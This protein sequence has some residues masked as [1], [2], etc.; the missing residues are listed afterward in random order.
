[1]PLKTEV[2]DRVPTY[3]GRVK[4]TPVS[5]LTNIYDMERADA[6]VTEGTPLNAAL[7]NQKAYTLIGAATV[8]VSKTGSD[9]VGDGSEAAPFASVQKAIDSLPKC[10]GGFH[11]QIDIGAGTYEE[12]VTIDG[13][14]G[15]RL[16]VGVTG[17]TVTLR[18]ITVMSSS[19]VRINISNLTYS[20]NYAGTLLYADHGSNVSIINALTLRGESAAVSGIAAARGSIITASVT[21]AVLG[22]GAAAV[23]AASGATI[24]LATINGNTGNTSYG[25]RADTGGLITFSSKGLV[26]TAGDTTGSGGR[27]LT[28]AGT[29]LANASVV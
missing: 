25:L 5:G 4:M 3:P 19:A 20:A 22:C 13:F 23:Y 12:R 14:Y 28:G 15:G 7:F 24:Q 8:Y 26:G 1:M 21:T 2:I 27:I 9:V 17:R 18:G 6:P 11:A 29:A 16:T 10:L